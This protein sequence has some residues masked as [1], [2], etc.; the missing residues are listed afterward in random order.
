MT[1]TKGGWIPD[2]SGLHRDDGIASLDRHAPLTPRPAFRTGTERQNAPRRVRRSQR[3][4]SPRRRPGPIVLRMHEA[5]DEP[6][7]TVPQIRKGPYAPPASRITRDSS[8]SISH[9]FN[10]RGP[11]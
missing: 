7:C 8:P 10:P 3:P 5:T 1:S 11:R 2:S 9:D 4:P 6:A